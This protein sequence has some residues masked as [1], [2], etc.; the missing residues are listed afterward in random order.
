MIA[1][2]YKKFWYCSCFL[3]Y[4]V[5]VETQPKCTSFAPPYETFERDGVQLNC[6]F[7]YNRAR[8]SSI[9]WKGVENAPE[10]KDN[11]QTISLSYFV[12]AYAPEV[13]SFTCVTSFAADNNEA[14]ITGLATN[15]PYATCATSAIKVHRMYLIHDFNIWWEC[16]FLFVFKICLVEYCWW[17]NEKFRNFICIIVHM[18]KQNELMSV[19]KGLLSNT[20]K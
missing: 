8:I 20:S 15:I 12:D 18:Q 13:P 10:V 11:G 4:C 9:V 19:F 6:M 7:T 5:I 14:T 3:I 1:K 17:T 16:S 2:F